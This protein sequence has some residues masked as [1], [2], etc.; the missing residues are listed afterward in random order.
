MITT[1]VDRL[2]TVVE[3][4]VDMADH[5]DGLTA[6]ALL[7]QLRGL[8]TQAQEMPLPTRRADR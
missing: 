4:V 8:A 3:M 1:D 5:G 6:A 7:A 2:T